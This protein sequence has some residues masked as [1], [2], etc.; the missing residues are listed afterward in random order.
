MSRWRPVKRRLFIQR[1]IKLGFDGPISGTRHEFMVYQG[2]RLAI[3]SNAE[4]SVPQLHFML[5]EVGTIVGHAISAEEWQSL[6][7]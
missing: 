4:F 2:Q 1:L 3:P 5:R 6:K 7:R